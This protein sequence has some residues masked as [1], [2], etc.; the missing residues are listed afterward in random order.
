MIVGKSIQTATEVIAHRLDS[1]SFEENFAWLCEQVPRLALAV[2]TPQQPEWHGEGSVYN[3]LKMVFAE[4]RVLAATLPD[5]ERHVLLLASLL[6]DVGKTWCTRPREDAKTGRT[7]IVSPRHAGEGAQYLQLLWDDTSLPIAW[8]DA[9]LSLVAF[10]H[11]PARLAESFNPWLLAYVTRHI[12]GK[13]LYLLELADIRGRIAA[14]KAGALERLEM[15]RLFCEEHECYERPSDL[16]RRLQKAMGNDSAVDTQLLTRHALIR[17]TFLDPA[18]GVACF[19][20]PT[21][22]RVVM[23]CGLAGSGKSTQARSLAEALDAVIIAPDDFR[24][25]DDVKARSDA[26]RQAIQALKQALGQGRSVI[27]DACNVR[28]DYR[29]NIERVAAAYNVPL[30]VVPV[31]TSPGDAMRRNRQRTGRDRVPDEVIA[32]QF[33]SFE[34]LD[35]TRYAFWSAEEVVASLRR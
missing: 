28:Q 13:L 18:Q 11:H 21:A 19:H 22:Q 5:D 4:A 12:P 26:W 35:L 30:G 25:R 14:D 3:H 34:R 31:M 1:A 8:R 7:L 10:H 27:Y 16:D 29:N 17:G 6:H 9:V 23:M 2:E 33:E 24:T 32:R 15:F 20:A